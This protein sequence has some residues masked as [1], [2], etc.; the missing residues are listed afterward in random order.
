[1]PNVSY[2][3]A[4]Y[5]V[6][7]TQGDTFTETL[8]FRDGDGDLIAL[9][10]YTFQSQVRQTPAGTVVADMTITVD[11]STVTRSIGT[12]VTATMAGDYEHDLD[13]LTPGG[14][15]R[16]LLAGSFKVVSEISR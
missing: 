2:G 10:G 6:T 3:P 7:M 9:D 12:A 13:W 8:T 1:M 16:T 5:N 14:V 15:R 11:G 4:V